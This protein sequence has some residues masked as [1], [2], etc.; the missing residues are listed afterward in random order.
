MGKLSFAFLIGYFDSALFLICPS[1]SK[2]LKNIMFILLGVVWSF[3]WA[4][5]PLV[6]EK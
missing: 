6:Y 1:F 2:A 5:L 3:P 4:Q